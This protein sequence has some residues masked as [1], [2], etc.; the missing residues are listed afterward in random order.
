MERHGFLLWEFVSQSKFSNVQPVQEKVC[1]FFKKKNFARSSMCAERN[2]SECGL[3]GEV[4]LVFLMHLVY[5][6]EIYYLTHGSLIRVS[7]IKN[8][9]LI[10]FLCFH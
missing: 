1:L 5:S 3:V 9:L 2:G 10:I 7:L 8:W 6:L 4:N